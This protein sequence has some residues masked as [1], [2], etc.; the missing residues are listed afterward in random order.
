MN[1]E[2]AKEFVTIAR[3][4]NLSAAAKELNLSTATLSARLKNFESYLGCQL[5]Y[6]D[7]NR[8]ILS[9]DGARFLVDAQ[10][11]TKD[12]TV[13]TET[14]HNITDNHAYRRLR[15]AILGSGMPPHLGPFLDILNRQNPYMHLELYDATE[16]SIADGIKNDK[17]DLYF[18]PS[19]EDVSYDG[20]GRINIAPRNP[21]LLISKD[22]PL[23]NKTSISLKEL[24]HETFILYPPTAETTLRDYQLRC[25][26]SAGI[27]Y[28]IYEDYAAPMFYHL[29]VPIGKGLLITP[30]LE[31]NIPPNSVSLQLTD[32]PCTVYESLFYNRQNTPPEV[33]MFL[34]DFRAFSRE[35]RSHGHGTSL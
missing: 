16:Y 23:N 17:I 9:E 26:N 34:K 19:M 8:L 10:E 35:A 3:C 25:L 29:L 6:R 20:I 12:Y 21:R 4:Q 27:H 24:D 30:L 33:K 13:L 5:F 28:Q 14:L 18:S 32:S 22:H 1:I 11:I 15:I 2:R 31:P 7:N